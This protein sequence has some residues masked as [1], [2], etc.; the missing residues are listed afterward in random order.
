M[1]IDDINESV[2]YNPSGAT[3]GSKLVVRF[4]G[5]KLRENVDYKV[6]YKNNKKSGTASYSITF[7]GDYKGFKALTDKSQTFTISKPSLGDTD[8]VN[9]V[10]VDKIVK[11]QGAYKSAPIVTY[12]GTKVAANEYKV[13]YYIDGEE[14]TANK[15]SVSDVS[16]V[17]VKIVS[18]GKT[19]ASDGEHEVCTYNVWNSASIDNVSLNIANAK[20]VNISKDKTKVAYTGSEVTLESG[21]DITIT[22]KDGTIIQGDDFTKNFDVLYYNNIKVGKA[23]IVIKAKPDSGYIGCKTATFTITKQDIK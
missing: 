1:T 10:S 8:N 9:A 21:K 14:I 23:T 22:R 4:D 15:I 20:K 16:T 13:K 3:L 2:S 17:T 11:N 6:T 12:M 7:I 5:S 18:T 19:Y